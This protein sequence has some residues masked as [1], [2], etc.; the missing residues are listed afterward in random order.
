MAPRKRRSRATS[1]SVTP[2]ATGSATNSHVSS[3]SSNRHSKSDNDSIDRMVVPSFVPPKTEIAPA[4]RVKIRPLREITASDAPW[5]TSL[6][7]NSRSETIEEIDIRAAKC[8]NAYEEAHKIIVENGGV[9]CNFTTADVAL[10]LYE[11][12]IN[13]AV[14][15]VVVQFKRRAYLAHETK[16]CT[17]A[18]AKVRVADEKGR[19][20]KKTLARV[21]PASYGSCLLYSERNVTVECSNCNSNISASRYAQHVEKCLGRG[22]RMSSRAASARLR[23][24]AERAEKESQA[25]MDES[26]PRRRRHTSN[27]N[28]RSA[29]LGDMPTFSSGASKRRRMSPVPSVGSSALSQGSTYGR[30]LPPSGRTRMSPR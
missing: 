5:S 30:G 29:D 6:Q 27:G 10:R 26:P 4:L 22:G 16:R 1:V 28:D 8:A 17:S 9:D 24:S 11:H 18:F 21:V 13:W 3:P 2:S 23:A 25:E 19:H 12:M 15:E 20:E 7:Q 14:T